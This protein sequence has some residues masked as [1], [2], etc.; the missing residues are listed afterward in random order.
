MGE[1]QDRGITKPAAPTRPDLSDLRVFDGH[2]DLPWEIR[3]AG[4]D[5]RVINP[6]MRLGGRTHTDLER[7]AKGRVG[8][9][10]WSVYA[11][12][13]LPEQEALLTTLEQIDL[14]HR[15]VSLHSDHLTLA[16][17]AADCQRAID[18][19]RI[20]SFIGAEGGHCI[21]SSLGVLRMLHRLGVRYLT[22]T[23]NHGTAWADSATDVARAGG[24]SDF[25]REV[26]VEMNRIG[27]IVDLSHVAPS[28]MHAALEATS[29]PILFSHSSAWALVDHPRNVPDDILMQLPANG[30]VCQVTFVPAFV[31]ESCRHWLDEV[32]EA[33]E[34]EG[35]DGNDLEA[36]DRFG[37]EFAKT[38]PRPRATVADVADHIDHVREVAGVDHVGLGGDFDGTDDLPQGLDDVS[39]YPNLIAELRD[40]SWSH[41]EL[42]KLTWKN[43]VRVVGEVCG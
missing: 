15:M 3:Q 36:R 35:Q 23:H 28:T 22:L 41:D 33:M 9:Q 26:V 32:S 25:G 19:G 10:F 6:G 43:V 42:A 13:T 12:S 38:H 39:C 29:K 40:R 7:L 14:V 21:A 16:T 24:L 37:S 8:A 18:E 20:A 31:S 4:G 34:A 30:G 17:S 11:P 2:N 5:L 27:M 1:W